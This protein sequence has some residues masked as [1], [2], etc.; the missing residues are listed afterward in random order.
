MTTTTFSPKA[1]RYADK[2]LSFFGVVRSEFLK[3]RTLTTNWVMTGVLAV[4]VI[5]F[6]MLGGLF[7]NSMYKSALSAAEMEGLPAGSVDQSAATSF[8]N[9]VFSNGAVSMD[10]ANMLIA[11]IAVVFVASEYATRSIST[12]L[13]TVPKRSMVFFA[14]LLMM[15]VYSF[16]L[17][18]VL[19][20]LGFFASYAILEP[21]IRDA[22]P[23]EVGVLYNC[24]A[25]AAY[26]MMLAWMGI[27]FGALMRNN[28]GGIVLVV[29]CLF[30]L[31]IMFALFAGGFEWATNMVPYMP[32]LLGH[33]MVAYE[34]AADAKHNNLEAAGYLAIWCVVPA[35]LGYLRFRFTDSK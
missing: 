32:N 13:A 7:I 33:S 18:F 22:N 1:S 24:L 26:F 2:K 29:S 31:P 20:L 5:G 34:V 21:A 9:D 30:V 6:A 3:F 8:A 15:S 12:T 16:T 4:V 11:S 10:M 23:F 28:A 19:S 35:V 17:G 27:G 25:V 14:K